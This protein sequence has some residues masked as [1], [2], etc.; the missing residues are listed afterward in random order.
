MQAIDL[1]FPRLTTVS[2]VVITMHQKPDG[3]AMGSALGLYHFLQSFGH[4]VTVISPTNWANF[5]DWMPGIEKVVD[6]ERWRD[7][8]K[9][10]ISEADWIFCL[11]FNVLHRTKHMEQP[12]TQAQCTKILIDH[13]EQPQ[14]EAFAYG[15]S[16][17]SKSST[18][19][20]VYDFIV[21]SGHA[22]KLSID[23]AKCLY[24]GVMTDTGSFRF[25][26]TTASVHRMVAH[27]KDLGLEHTPVH[28]AIY[29]NFL[30]T[31]LRFIGYALLNRMEVFYEYNTALMYITKADLQRFDIKT[32]DTEGLVNYLLTIR[33]I[34]LGAI[35]VD[36][37]EERKWSFRSKGHFDVN[38]FARTHFEGGGHHNA[39]GGR[40]SDSLETTA[41][42]FKEVIKLYQNQLQ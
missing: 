14:A 24:T 10:L 41:A 21:A 13:H 40:S 18:C 35:V 31:R 7:R 32:G 5:L 15:I 9:A 1:F 20:M 33:G 2:K 26:S 6:Y 27:L 22:D 25:P 37:D 38:T 39:S 23:I 17:T 30:E 12:L 3:D 16:D 11:D 19:E 36:R 8:G 28:E 34:K 4:D 29:D 42:H